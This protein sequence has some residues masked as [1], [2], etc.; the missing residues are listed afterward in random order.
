MDFDHTFFTA[1]PIPASFVHIPNTLNCVKLFVK[2][3]VQIFP[4]G[5]PPPSPYWGDHEQP[6]PPLPNHER[7]VGGGGVALLKPMF[8][9]LTTVLF[10]TSAHKPHNNNNNS[11]Y[12][13]NNNIIHTHSKPM[14]LQQHC[15][16]LSTANLQQL[17]KFSTLCETLCVTV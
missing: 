9:R 15:V 4:M 12:Y 8:S 2:V 16:N 5:L 7:G 13:H 14:Q 17:G 3:L 1:F 11:V 6:P 10:E